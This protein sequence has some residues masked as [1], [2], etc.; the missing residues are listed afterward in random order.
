[1]SQMNPKKSVHNTKYSVQQS[2]HCRSLPL[3]DKHTDF[4]VIVDQSIV[5]L[6]PMLI[7]HLLSAWRVTTEITLTATL[8]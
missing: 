4:S 3:R 2:I 8:I 1:M 7:L 6:V 5:E